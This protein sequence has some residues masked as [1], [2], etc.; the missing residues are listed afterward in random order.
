MKVTYN[1]LKDFVE[2]KISPQQLADKLTMA[3]LE[4]TSLEEKAGDFVF[5][6]EV[7]SNRPDCLSVVGIAREAA[8]ITNKK[9][10]LSQATGHRS[11]VEKLRPANCDLQLKIENK[12]DCPLY[13]AKIIK[14]VK[15]GSSPDWLKR[16]L[17]L[18]GCRSVN[19][20]VDITNYILFEWGEP[21]HAFDLDKLSVGTIIVRRGREGEK[22]ITIDGQERILNPEI[23]VIADKEKAVAVAGI[24]GGKDTEVSAGAKNILLEAAVFNP[25]VIRRGRQR[26]G[27]S[28]ESAYRFERGVDLENA[29]RAAWQAVALIQEICGGRCVLAKPA[30]LSKG[31]KKKVTLDVASCQKILGVNI[32]AAKIKCLLQHLDFKVQGK[33]KN[34][35]LVEVPSHRQDINLSVDLIEE[36]ARIYGYERIP[37]TLPKVTAQVATTGTASL[38]SLIKNILVGLGLNEVITYSLIDEGALAVLNPQM[39]SC[40]V[41]IANPLSKEQEILRP[42]IIPGLCR[43]VAN[44]LNQKQSYINIFEVSRIFSQEGQEPKEELAL[45]IALCGVKSSLIEQGL[46]KEEVGLLHLKGIIE[47][48][49]WRL[50]IKDYRFK[51]EDGPAKISVLLNQEK[52]GMMTNL[53]PGSL[54]KFAIKNKAVWVAELLLDR[55]FTH[56]DLEKK[57]VPLPKY[58]GISRDLSV[59]LRDGVSLDELLRAMKEKGAPLLQEVKIVDYYKGKQIPAGYRG[60]TFSCLYRSQERTLTE[61]EINPIHA[62]VSFVL[63]DKFNAQIRKT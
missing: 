41:A 18:I 36:V 20:V 53:S 19:S 56:L 54:E 47:H 33:I 30:G 58:P 48:L 17:E 9:I 24:M 4:V 51:S 37:K 3:G 25:I 42:T 11:Q 62:L 34:S 12:K 49:F 32:P 45:G 35:L 61:A 60:L 15:V 50:G 7:T 55:I 23:L 38:V 10:K 8:A 52:I 63:A 14:D 28:S 40:A 26:L 13:T 31:K 27:L 29:Q 22:I 46:I 5:E 2:I 57:A 39:R 59:I 43:A 1:W 44:N 21:L 6:I 16:R